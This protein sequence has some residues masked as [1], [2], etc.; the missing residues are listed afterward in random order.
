M[1]ID[2][3]HRIIAT[4]LWKH[5]GYHNSPFV[6]M[7]GCWAVFDGHINIFERCD[8]TGN[9]IKVKD[10]HKDLCSK[11]HK[12]FCSECHRIIMYPGWSDD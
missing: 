9:V 11:R 4:W 5:T 2:N 10:A 6:C 1:T 7:H 12:I 8:H 3:I